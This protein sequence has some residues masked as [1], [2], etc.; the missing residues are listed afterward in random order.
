MQW[1]CDPKLLTD[2][3]HAVVASFYLALMTHCCLELIGAR[4]II[5]VEGAFAENDAYVAMLEAATG[6]QV[7][8]SEGTGT[9]QGAAL[10]VGGGSKDSKQKGAGAVLEHRDA[11]N[12][13]GKNWINLVSKPR[14]KLN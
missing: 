2:G 3:E 11:M 14:E 13:Y 8:V 7:V 4:G 6:R 1:T 5:F 12:T 9:S 10:L